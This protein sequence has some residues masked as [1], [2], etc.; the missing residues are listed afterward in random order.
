V[1]EPG[2]EAKPGIRTVRSIR[3]VDPEAWD[4]LAGAN[5]LLGHGWLRSMEEA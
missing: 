3:D 1:T 2:G 5:P 4:Q